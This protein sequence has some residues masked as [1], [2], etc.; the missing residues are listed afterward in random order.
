MST[1]SIMMTAYDRAHLLGPTLES[2]RF[3]TRQVEQIVVVE[4]GNDGGK[5]E[6]VC[7][8]YKA[9]GL[10]VEYFR[11]VNRPAVGFS[12]PA[13]PKN[14]G[15]RKCIGEILI[16][17]S[18]E[19]KYTKP[20]DVENLVVPVEANPNVS[21]FAPCHS[22]NQDGSEGIWYGD[23]AHTHYLGFCHAVRRDRVVAIGGYD[24]RFRGYGR[25]DDDFAWRL[26]VS[27]ITYKW[28]PEVL[29]IHQWHPGHPDPK[30]AENDKF[31]S[32]L[33]GQVIEDYYKNK[34]RGLESN[35]GLDWG[36]INS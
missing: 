26:H 3:Q 23:P 36:N 22:L 1:L 30:D 33:G 31:N 6:A 9:A 2:L 35:V 12:N 13:V 29:T 7:A 21:M 34:T 20:M 19:V 16:I 32:E 27:G 24:E 4:D 17:Q 11:R 8:Q 28:A 5:T 10:P 15:I 25:E 14:I 18:A